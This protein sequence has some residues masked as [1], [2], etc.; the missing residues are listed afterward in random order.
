MENVG[1][2]GI[3]HVSGAYKVTFL[4]NE[5][6]TKLTRGFDSKYLADKFANKLRHSKKCTIL[7]YVSF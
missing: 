7:S 4:V 5:S 3:E 2:T 1:Y 6:N